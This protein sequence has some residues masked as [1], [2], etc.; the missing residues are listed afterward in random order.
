MILHEMVTQYGL[1][2]HRWQGFTDP[3][4]KKGFEKCMRM[5]RNFLV[6][7]TECNLDRII[8][9]EEAYNYPDNTRRSYAKGV[10]E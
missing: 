7:E 8:S 3:A 4:Q 10:T 1:M 6:Y 9:I 2:L 5:Y